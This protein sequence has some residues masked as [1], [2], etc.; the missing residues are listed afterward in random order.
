MWTC[1]KC[2]FTLP[3]EH[4]GVMACVCGFINNNIEIVVKEYSESTNKPPNLIQKTVN[5]AGA[6]TNH[7]IT[8]MKRCTQEQIDQRMEICKKC[9][10]FIPK[11]DGNGIC[12]H[13]S[14]GCNLK[15][16]QVFLNKLAW[17]E[18]KCPL[19]KWDSI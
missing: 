13:S 11:E 18:Q 19:N 3:I 4:K 17:A 12:G 2:G 1:Q 7:V 5:F 6:F 15:N 10:I 14:C 8:G 9:E 16:E